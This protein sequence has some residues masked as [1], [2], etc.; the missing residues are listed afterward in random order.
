MAPWLAN[1]WQDVDDEGT[2]RFKFWK[3][4]NNFKAGAV[5]LRAN[6]SY[7][8]GAFNT[9]KGVFMEGS[10]TLP[11]NGTASAGWPGFRVEMANGAVATIGVGPGGECVVSEASSTAGTPRVAGSWDRELGL[12]PGSTVR[13]T[14]LYDHTRTRTR[15]AALAVLPAVAVCVTLHGNA[16]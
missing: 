9:S 10:I 8:A 2:L 16:R 14:L 6:G 11:A 1:V 4:N 5:P 13:V 7:F 12:A 15:T 3:A